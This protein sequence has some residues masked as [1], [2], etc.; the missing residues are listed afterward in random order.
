[1]LA[2]DIRDINGLYIKDLSK[3]IVNQINPVNFAKRPF[4][5]KVLLLQLLNIVNQAKN[6]NSSAV[7]NLV[8]QSLTNRA[9]LL[10]VKVK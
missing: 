3:V 2:E 5:E 6:Q 9:Q 7:Y 10:F 8:Q 4:D 1:L